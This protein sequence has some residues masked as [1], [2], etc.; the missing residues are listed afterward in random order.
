MSI[1]DLTANVG[2]WLRGHG[3]MGDIVISSRI[4]LARNLVGYPFLSRA[5]DDQQREIFRTLADAVGNTSL[6]QNSLFFD[7]EEMDDIDKQVLVERHLISQQQAGGAGSR[8]VNV[9]I[10]ETRALMINEEDHLRLQVLRSGLELE[11]LWSEIDAIDDALSEQVEF[12]FDQRLGFLTACPTNVGTGLRVSVMLHLPALKMTGEIEKVLR[13]AKD[14]RLAVRGLF[15]EGTDAVGDFYQWSNQITLGRSEIDFI[16]EFSTRIIP[17]VVEYEKAAR[18]ALSNE[19][20]SQLD[21]KIWR[22]FGVLE[23]ARTLASDETMY[24]LSH[25]RMGVAMGRLDLIDV[26]TINE[27][28][29]QI[30]P[31]HLQKAQGGKLSGEQRSVARAEMIR[32]QLG[33]HRNN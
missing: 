8:G 33:H 11:T 24:L 7:L 21:D 22:A 29:L 27:L 23:N 10:D 6:G 25:V 13:A 1:S 4:R 18:E 31:A 17:R 12:A 5:T 2:E 26:G 20:S 28:L 14:L 30:Q 32:N 15:G 9:S 19:R 16:E 3:P